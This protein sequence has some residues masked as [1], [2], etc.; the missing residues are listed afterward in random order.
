MSKKETRK[1]NGAPLEIGNQSTNIPYEDPSRKRSVRTTFRLEKD[2]F[3]NMESLSKYYKITKKELIEFL[4]DTVQTFADSS[5]QGESLL[6][7]MDNKTYGQ[8][9]KADLIRKTQVISKKSLNTLNRLSKDT[10]L[11]RDQLI[12]LALIIYKTDLR[13][14]HK[15][16]EKALKDINKLIS[17]INETE[18][19][20]KKF[21]DPDDPVLMRFAYI[22]IVTD[23]LCSAIRSEI[24][25][26]VPIDPDD[27]AQSV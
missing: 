9:Q 4:V 24:D 2:T 1:I 7:S 12:T 20:L 8:T 6:N 17:K 26:G 11:S 25:K 5:E 27:F 18:N 21:L 15:N 14:V 10:E 16:H 23:N 19:A 13:Q 3:S 22:A